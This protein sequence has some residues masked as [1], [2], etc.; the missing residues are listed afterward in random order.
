MIKNKK[1]LPDYKK[2]Q[3]NRIS[4]GNKITVEMDM[5]FFA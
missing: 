3:K 2:Y 4:H 1:N 5:V